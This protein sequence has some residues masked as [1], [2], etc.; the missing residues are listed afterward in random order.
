MDRLV[1]QAI[2]FWVNKTLEGYI[3]EFSTENNQSFSWE[4]VDFKKYARGRMLRE[5]PMWIKVVMREEGMLAMSSTEM[6]T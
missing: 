6:T 1:T 2:N 4:E 3:I 5:I